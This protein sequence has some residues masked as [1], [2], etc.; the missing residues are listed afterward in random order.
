M[1]KKLKIGI[2]NGIL[3]EPIKDFFKEAGY[4]LEI[5]ESPSSVFIGDD[6]IECFLGGSYEL[7]ILVE[8][9]I[10]DGTIVS[11]AVLFESGYKKAKEV[12]AIGS[13]YYK[14]KEG[15]KVVIA[16]SKNS[17]IKKIKDLE[18]KKIIT[19]LP[20]IAKDFL[21]KNKI[22]AFL[23]VS[24]GANEQKV[25]GLADAVIEFLNTGRTLNF[26]NLRVLETILEGINVISLIA[27]PKALKDSWKKEKLENLGLLLHSARLAKDYAGLM[28][29]ASNDMMEQVFEILPSLK[30]PTVTHLRGENWFDVFTV[31]KKNEIR[32]LIPKL[33]KIGCT[34][35]VEF[36]LKKVII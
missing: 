35:I 12:R 18:G 3:L 2:P 20:G 5:K 29:H 33:K 6:D 25:P 28:L 24:Q 21:K 22:S 17:K 4:E 19:R 27:N 8:R 32:E 15:T 34:D 9:G 13:P 30:K 31:A 36:S 1:K 10:L 11:K 16:V 23:E 7:P 14:W 26:Y